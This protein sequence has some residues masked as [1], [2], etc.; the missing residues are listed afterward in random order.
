[1]LDL[2]S[3]L[4]GITVLYIALLK[5][6]EQCAIKVNKVVEFKT[7]WQEFRLSIFLLILYNTYLLKDPLFVTIWSNLKGA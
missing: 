7:N 3:V 2:I 1:M 4:D 5:T 6:T